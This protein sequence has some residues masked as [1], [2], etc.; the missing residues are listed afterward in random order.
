MAVADDQ[1]VRSIT[2]AAGRLSATILNV[3]AALMDFAVDMQGGRRPLILSLS[4]ANAYRTN[5]HYLGAIAG[6]CA[7]RIRGGACI[8]DGRLHQLDRNENGETH[9]HGGPKGFSRKFWNI[10]AH[11]PESVDLALHS[12][13]TDQ[14]YPGNL[15]CTCRYELLPGNRMRITLSATA[16][17]TTLVNLAAHAYFTL[18]PQSS[19]L[20]HALQIAAEHY[21]P[22]DANLIPDGRQLAVRGTGFD[23]TSLS[24]IGT[25]RE[26]TPAGFDHN[27]ILAGAPRHEPAF[28][29]RLRS[30]LQDLSLEIWTTEPGLQFYDGAK[31]QGDP[32][33]PSGTLRPFA[34]CCLEPQRFPDAIHH[35]HFAGA[36]LPAGAVYRQVTEYRVHAG[37]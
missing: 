35:P 4:D 10:V 31:L 32:T 15:D 3:G 7:N 11:T 2:I 36:L 28:A 22:V 23:F 9:L 26:G 24:R 14:G 8:I 29:A 13:D 27:F 33:N 17:A 34:G 30:P 5:P 25:Q 6:R 12:P 20:D 18:A 37:S 16:D 1:D 21:T 19:V